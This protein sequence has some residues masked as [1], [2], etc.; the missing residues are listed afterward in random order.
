MATITVRG[1]G[2]ARARPDE[3][4]ITFE[5]VSV[6]DA[7]AEAFAEVAE[8]TAELERVLDEVGVPEPARSTS[9]IGLHPYQ[10]H[11]PQGAPRTRHRAFN[12]IGL[13]LADAERVPQ[14]LR[15]SVERAQAEVQGPWWRLAD[16]NPARL[17][18]CR[19]AAGE[20]GLR[21][22]A[23]AAA[24][25][26]RLGPVET[27]AEVTGGGE[28]G[29]PALGF[30]LTDAETPLHPGELEATTAVDVTYATEPA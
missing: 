4:L 27:V 23:Y 9:G 13:R 7:P 18:A 24:L 17:E 10:E 21:A 28:V 15:A 16:D 3:V 26:L 5:V 29:R 1:R 11:D 8:R 19:L 14:L 25:G 6:G 30:T 22:E 20:A 2:T 12:R